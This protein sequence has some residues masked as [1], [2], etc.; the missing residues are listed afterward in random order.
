[1]TRNLNYACNILKEVFKSAGEITITRWHKA[2]DRLF[3]RVVELSI[4]TIAQDRVSKLDQLGCSNT[5]SNSNSLRW[6]LARKL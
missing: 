6:N 2:I 3:Q 4:D 1:M 5:S